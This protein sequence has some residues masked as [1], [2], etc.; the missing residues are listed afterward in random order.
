MIHERANQPYTDTTGRYV[1]SYN[2]E[3]YNFQQLRRELSHNYG[4]GNWK[5]NSDTEVILQGFILE[6][7]SFLKKLNGF[8]ALVIYDKTTRDFFVLRDPLGIKPLFCCKLDSNVFFSSELNILLN[9]PNFKPTIRKE[10][11]A[12]QLAFMYVPEPRTLFNEI[13]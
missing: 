2:G 1:I 9:L 10:S 7:P 12:E 13:K 11:L 6:G 3:V 8:F 5:T 4:F